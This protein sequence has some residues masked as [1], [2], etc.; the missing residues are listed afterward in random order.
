M[1]ALSIFKWLVQQGAFSVTGRQERNAWGSSRF[2]R[3]GAN[4]QKAR[5]E[6]HL[7]PLL[8]FSLCLS[9]SLPPS[10]SSP[11]SYLLVKCTEGTFHCVPWHSPPHSGM[12][13]ARTTHTTVV[14]QLSACWVVPTTPSLKKEMNKCHGNLKK[15][16]NTDSQEGWY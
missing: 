8:K 14:S 2:T 16:L 4:A 3:T 6:W 7:P 9:L 11:V 12:V 13:T 10:H 1:N 15:L 5:G